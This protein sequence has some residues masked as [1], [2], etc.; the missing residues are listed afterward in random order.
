[1]KNPKDKTDRFKKSGI[2]EIN[3]NDYNE[4]YYS[5]SRKAFKALHSE[6]L[7]H[8]RKDRTEDSSVSCHVLYE[9]YSAVKSLMKFVRHVTD[10]TLLDAPERLEIKVDSLMNRS[11]IIFG[12][13]YNLLK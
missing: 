6:H 11:Q 8:I 9:G 2:H 1:M 3:W 4:K 12:C 10:R 5:Q 7:A 13:L